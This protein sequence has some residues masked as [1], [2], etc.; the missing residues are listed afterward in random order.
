MTQLIETKEENG[1]IIKVYA[2]APIKFG[3]S[4]KAKASSKVSRAELTKIQ[5]K[6]VTNEKTN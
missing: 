1:L 4:C 2:P 3:L 6:E 5:C